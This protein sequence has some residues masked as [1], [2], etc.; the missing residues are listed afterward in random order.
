MDR[1]IAGV[2]AGAVTLAGCAV[3]LPAEYMG[4]ATGLPVA[5]EERARIEA[6]AAGSVAPDRG[7]PWAGEGERMIEVPCAL[8]PASQLAA[9]AWAN[10]RPAALELGIRFEEGRGLPQDRDKARA[11]YRLASLKTGGTIYVYSPG[12]NGRPGHVMPVFL[13][14]EP[15]L[16]EARARLLAMGEEAEL[17][18]GGKVRLRTGD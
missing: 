2:L 18:G 7:C 5:P 17:P 16:P 6:A 3:S 10:N 4:I 15:G 13:P 8:L 14:E 11:L 12:V 9:L 1:R